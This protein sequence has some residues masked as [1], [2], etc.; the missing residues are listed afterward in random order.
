MSVLLCASGA[1][2]CQHDRRASPPETGTA[3]CDRRRSCEGGVA[4]R[5]PYAFAT[6]MQLSLHPLG[7]SRHR[8]LLVRALLYSC[9]LRAGARK[10]QLQYYAWQNP[11]AAAKSFCEQ[12]GVDSREA[13]ALLSNLLKPHQEQRIGAS[14]TWTGGCNFTLFVGNCSQAQLSC[15]QVLIFNR[16]VKETAYVSDANLQLALHSI[17]HATHALP[18]LSNL[19]NLQTILHRFGLDE[20]G[21]CRKAHRITVVGNVTADCRFRCAATDTDTAHMLYMTSAT[22]QAL[23]SLKTIDD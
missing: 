19:R 13:L 3:P 2:A 9:T 20:K 14:F 21:T 23:V 15:E 12:N 4:R 17:L 18:T 7:S 5:E 16:L 6:R 8:E 10:V 22:Q 1:A 11:I